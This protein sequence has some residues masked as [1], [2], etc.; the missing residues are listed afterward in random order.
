MA[1]KKIGDGAGHQ[2]VDDMSKSEV[3]AYHKEINEFYVEHGWRTTLSHFLLS[4]IQAG[5]IVKKTREKMEKAAK[6]DKDAKKKDRAAK[7][8]AKPAAKNKGPRKP[9]KKAPKKD[10]KSEEEE[11]STKKVS[12]PKKIKVKTKVKTKAKTK[13]GK[14]KVKAEASGSVDSE[15]VL[16]FLLAY[17]SSNTG[18]SLDT[19]IA[20]LATKVR[21]A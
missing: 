21:A 9:P 1:K 20:D 16:D 5:E 19:A 6:A 15:A 11:V 10:E 12:K 14:S 2:D 18:V 13:A 4:P 8:K 3:K 17:R 7:K